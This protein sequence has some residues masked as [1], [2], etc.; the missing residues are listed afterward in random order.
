M[1]YEFPGYAPGC[2]DDKEALKAVLDVL[3]KY[4]ALETR[5]RSL[6]TTTA[7]YPGQWANA[8]ANSERV[9]R[10]MITQHD[11]EIF[12]K[13]DENYRKVQGEISSALNS[14]K[15]YTNDQIEQLQAILTQRIVNLEEKLSALIAKY[16]QLT[17]F[18]YD[19]LDVVQDDIIRLDNNINGIVKDI[20]DITTSLDGL[21]AYIDI[22]LTAV[23]DHIT[24]LE[25]K[26]ISNV[27]VLKNPYTGVHDSIQKVID[28]IYNSLRT[29]TTMQVREIEASRITAGDVTRALMTGGEISGGGIKISPNDI[30]NPVT[31]E[32]RSFNNVMSFL[33]RTNGEWKSDQLDIDYDSAKAKSL[34]SYGWRFNGREF[35][36]DGW[37][38]CRNR[39][40]I[41]WK[42]RTWEFF[43]DE[44]SDNAITFICN[45]IISNIKVT[46]SKG[47]GSKIVPQFTYRKIPDSDLITV[48]TDEPVKQ[49]DVLLIY[50]EAIERG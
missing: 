41:F 13:I 49:G 48:T 32:R 35:E 42:Y 29:S 30:N 36:R 16:N 37:Y 50:I 38:L 47:D 40:S 1:A 5:V 11:T 12:N 17:R 20:G 26:M 43:Y 28:D 39:G 25:E 3:Q 19:K 18:V 44:I 9:T 15:L 27:N 34:D 2:G 8:I 31:G 10:N 6:E 22:E 33:P 24:R 4:E 14:A 21:R 45:G 7:Q 23:D 46:I